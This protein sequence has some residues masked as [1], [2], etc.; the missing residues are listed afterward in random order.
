MLA[1]EI[2]LQFIRKTDPYSKDG[3]EIAASNVHTLSGDAFTIQRRLDIYNEAR[4]AFFSALKFREDFSDR[5]S[6]AL[7]EASITWTLSGGKATAPMPSG[8]IQFVSMRTAGSVPM[9]L[10][11]SELIEIVEAG[12][13]PEFIQSASRIFIFEEGV[14]F[15]HYGAFVPTASTYKLKYSGVPALTIANI[16]TATAVTEVFADDDTPFLVE[17][18]CSIANEQ[19]E[20]DAL[21][22]AKKLLGVK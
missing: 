21:A 14:S 11:P 7:V 9:R 19:G 3:T 12:L 17:I 5:V 8:Y 4:F 16:T 20:S 6:G 10:L 22:L 15:S 18:A 2:L 13:N 1:Q